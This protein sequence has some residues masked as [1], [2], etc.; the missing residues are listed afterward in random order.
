MFKLYNS[1]SS[2]G[3]HKDLSSSGHSSSSYMRMKV[4][5]SLS[6]SPFL[7]PPCLLSPLCCCPS[8]LS[9]ISQVGSKAKSLGLDM[10]KGKW[11]IS[12][13]MHTRWVRD[14]AA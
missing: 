3:A 5:Q 1:E 8:P 9:Q 10:T 2:L 14:S 13:L 11:C 7:L 12:V 4:R 6:P